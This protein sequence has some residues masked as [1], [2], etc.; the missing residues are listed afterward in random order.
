M[1]DNRHARKMRR[2]RIVAGAIAIILVLSMVLGLI[3]PFVF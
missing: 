3:I 2:N 1:K